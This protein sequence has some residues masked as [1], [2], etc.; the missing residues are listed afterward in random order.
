MGAALARLEARVAWE[1]IFKVADD[2][3]VQQDRT[4]RMHSPQVRGFTHLPIR[5]KARRAALAS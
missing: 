4:E 1:E 5:F 2:F 3:E